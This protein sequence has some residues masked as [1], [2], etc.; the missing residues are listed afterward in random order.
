MTNKSGDMYF[1]TGLGPFLPIYDECGNWIQTIG[2][3]DVGVVLR[4]IET[5]VKPPLNYSDSFVAPRK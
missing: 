5:C 2:P 4:T 3:T 1:I